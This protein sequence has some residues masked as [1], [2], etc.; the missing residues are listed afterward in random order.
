MQL[1][2]VKDPK[3]GSIVKIENGTFN[4]SEGSIS[5]DD[6]VERFNNGKIVGYLDESTDESDND[7]E[8]IE[9]NLEENVKEALSEAGDLSEEAKNKMAT[10]FESAVNEKVNKHTAEIQ[11]DYNQKL[12]EKENEI[13]ENVDNYLSYAVKEWKK[14]NEIALQEGTRSEMTKNILNDIKKIFENYNIDLP[15]EKVDEVEKLNSRVEKLQSKLDEQYE[16]NKRLQEQISNSEKEDIIEEVGSD[17][18]STDFERFKGLVEDLDFTSIDRFKQKAE[19][20]LEAHFAKS[21]NDSKPND[22]GASGTVSESTK[23]SQG[24]SLAEQAAQFFKNE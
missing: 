11:N 20:I 12:E 17:L 18:T 5:H 23:G 6:A 19:T 8:T 15:E 13:V 3:T 21:G 4:L 16:E 9:V 7:Y 24:S 14:E 2:K 10:L 1:E 22:E